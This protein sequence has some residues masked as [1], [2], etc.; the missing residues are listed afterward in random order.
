MAKTIEAFELTKE[1]LKERGR[2]TAANIPELQDEA[3]RRALTGQGFNFY[4]TVNDEDL[5]AQIEAKIG[6]A[7]MYRRTIDAAREIFQPLVKKTLAGIF[8]VAI[9]YQEEGA[10]P[11]AYEIGLSRAVNSLP[12]ARI[13]GNAPQFVSIELPDLYEFLGEGDDFERGFHDQALTL[14]AGRTNLFRTDA[15]ASYGRVMLP[16]TKSQV[17]KQPS[18]SLRYKAW[19]ALYEG[20]DGYTV[21]VLPSL[22]SRTLGISHNRVREIRIEFPEGASYEATIE[23][24]VRAWGNK[25]PQWL[26]LEYGQRRYSPKIRIPEGLAHSAT[27]QYS[28]AIRGL[29]ANIKYGTEGAGG[30]GFI[31][32]K[33]V[34]KQQDILPGNITG[35]WVQALNTLWSLIISIVWEDQVADFNATK[36][37]FKKESS[38][39]VS[40]SAPLFPTKAPRSVEGLSSNA[41]QFGSSDYVSGAVTLDD[42]LEVFGE[43]DDL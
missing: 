20:A 27:N 35:A 16:W 10:F 12:E 8:K 42:F 36:S 39:P 25:A 38:R 3:L 40:R 6:N 26:L 7:I 41:S 24:R 31:A 29:K 18:P 30:A 34:G 21:K 23:N 1:F 4:L 5:V 2:I 37:T 15:P 32:T 33:T 43:E 9:S 13:F 28:A 11:A 14:T 22:T 19:K 17:L